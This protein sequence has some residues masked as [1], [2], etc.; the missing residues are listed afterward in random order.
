MTGTKNEQIR[1]NM[2]QQNQSRLCKV[3]NT[4]DLKILRKIKLS[5]SR[6]KTKTKQKTFNLKL[7][8]VQMSYTSWKGNHYVCQVVIKQKN[9][10]NGRDCQSTQLERFL[11]KQV[12]KYSLTDDQ[13]K[14]KVDYALSLRSI[15]QK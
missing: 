1:R 6:H 2:Q 3:P 5:T 14:K 10:G 8:G 4:L 12:L 11:E 13:V 7:K 15:S 9:P